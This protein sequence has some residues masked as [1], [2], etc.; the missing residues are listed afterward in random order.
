MNIQLESTTQIVMVDGV[1][2]RIWEGHTAGGVRCH[3]IITRIACD[4]KADAT[5]FER[6]LKECRPPSREISLAYGVDARLL[7]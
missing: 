6:E 4:T 3:A 7:L 1:P 5:E 2:G